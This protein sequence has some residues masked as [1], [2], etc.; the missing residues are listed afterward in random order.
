MRFPIYPITKFIRKFML[1]H[2][3]DKS[4]RILILDASVRKIHL[5]S[6]LSRLHSSSYIEYPENDGFQKDID[7]F[8]KDYEGG[9]E[10]PFSYKRF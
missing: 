2:I 10:K 9:K 8:I 1:L 7:K 3:T 6:E 5:K 4:G